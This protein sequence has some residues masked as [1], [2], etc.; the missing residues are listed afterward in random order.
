MIYNGMVYNGQYLASTEDFEKL[1]V[2]STEVW[3]FIVYQY[4]IQ[5]N[6]LND[7]MVTST[8]NI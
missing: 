6:G 1:M 5:N 7:L 8:E 4:F 3:A 2:T